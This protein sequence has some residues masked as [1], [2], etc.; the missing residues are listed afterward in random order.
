VLCVN[1]MGDECILTLLELKH[2][3]NYVWMAKF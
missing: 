1:G 3:D 2:N